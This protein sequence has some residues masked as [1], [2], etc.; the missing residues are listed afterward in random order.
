MGEHSRSE[1]RRRG[2]DQLQ[3]ALQS[4]SKLCGVHPLQRLTPNLLELLLYDEGF[5]RTIQEL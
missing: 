1:L 4:Q 2:G 5:E 3:T